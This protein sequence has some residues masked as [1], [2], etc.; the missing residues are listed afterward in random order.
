M[1]DNGDGTYV[2]QSYLSRINYYDSKTEVFQP[3]DSTLKSATKDS[4]Q[5]FQ[6]VADAYHVTLPSTSGTGEWVSVESSRGAFS[7]RPSTDGTGTAKAKVSSSQGSLSSAKDAVGYLGAFGSGIGL[8]YLSSSEGLKETI[9][10]SKFTGITTFGF[11]L[12]SSNLTPVLQKNGA[13]WLMSAESTA[14]AFTIP[15]PTMED[16]LVNDFDEPAFSDKVHYDLTKT[17]SGWHLDVV[18]DKAWLSDPKRVYPVRIDPCVI[19]QNYGTY[20]AN[21]Y[22]AAM[23]AF[24]TDAYPNTNCG[25]SYD[26]GYGYQLKT[27]YYSGSGNNRTLIYPDVSD[28]AWWN[29]VS[30]LKIIYANMNL[31]CYWR[32]DHGTGPVWYGPIRT[33]WGEMSVTW[34]TQPGIEAYSSA[35]IT[36]GGRTR[37]DITPYVQQWMD[38]TY[39][40]FG[41]AFWG[42]AGTTGDWTKMYAR[43]NGSNYP[44]FECC[45]TTSPYTPF[46]TGHSQGPASGKPWVSWSYLDAMSKP[47]KYARIALWDDA[48]S[49]TDKWVYSTSNGT[50]TTAALP[51]PSGGWVDGRTYPISIQTVGD[52]TGMGTEAFSAWSS[53]DYSF[54]YHA[55]YPNVAKAVTSASTGWFAEA[56]TNG[57]GANDAMNDT[58][59]SGRGNVSL[60]WEATGSPTGYNIYL[61]DGYEFRQ[62]GSTT[63][64]SWATSGKALFPTDTAIAALPSGTTAN[65]FLA[66][67]GL[68]LRDDPR[69]L[70]AKTAGSDLDSSTSY[71]FKVVPYNSFGEAPRSQVPTVSVSLESRTTHLSDDPRHT[72]YSLGDLFG[73]NAL[74]RFDTGSIELSTVDLK[75]PGLG[76]D[77]LLARHYSSASTATTSTLGQPGWRFSFEQSLVISNNGSTATYTDANGDTHRFTLK[78]TPNASATGGTKTTLG[79]DTIHTFTSS[80]SLNVTGQITEA[81]VLVVGG[82]GGGYWNLS[83]G[84]GGG[85]VI[86][87]SNLTLSGTTAVSVGAGGAGCSANGQ[88][89]S[90]GSTVAIGGGRAASRDYSAYT[91]TSGGS[92]GGGAGAMPSTAANQYGAAGTA[93]QGYAGGNGIAPDLGADTAGGGGG[94]AGGP[95]GA[96]SYRTGGA[97]GPGK[98]SNITGATAY[99]GGGGGGCSYYANGAGGIGGGGSGAGQA[100]AANT[101]GG[102]GGGAAGGSGIVIV[103]YPTPGNTYSWISPTGFAG[104]LTQSGSDYKIT[105]KDRSVVTFSSDGRLKTVADKNGNTVSY[106]WGSSNLII[107]AVGDT[108]S[109]QRRIT[110]SFDANRKVTSAVAVTPDGTRSAAYTYGTN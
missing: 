101:G 52:T 102:G 45:F 75:I 60:S 64:T 89:S 66:G 77:A 14:P 54:T 110:V 58:N 86:D 85:G 24:I 2:L 17:D 44:V 88:N 107:K 21:G 105:L 95:G 74:M 56:D 50:A 49:G 71:A 100:G 3:V 57:D 16:S 31:G 73:N 51:E 46:V 37:F 29:G 93:G 81:R 79:S 109:H 68:D 20:Q 22:T 91:A 63:T 87:T 92:G 27:G 108:D 59:A 6:N 39:S 48:L 90:F 99:Y 43:E 82:G 25:A 36:Q 72:D 7:W 98:A 35:N 76:V 61:S 47:Q 28:I 84:G 30:H 69:P 96:G 1:F 23:D 5:V 38:G 11:D 40:V 104:T 106:T 9:T 97:G 65:A 83:G 41:I 32:Y 26:S 34:N 15:A 18:A 70:Y 8:E 12:A 103:R 80:G 19:Y 13:I 78:T 4:K 33:G 55:P 42:R 94:G 67:T 10:L 62:V 53:V